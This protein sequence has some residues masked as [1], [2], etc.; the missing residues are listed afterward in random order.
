MKSPTPAVPLPP[1]EAAF[2]H[3]SL[4]HLQHVEKFIAI[5]NEHPS[6]CLGFHG[7][8]MVCLTRPHNHYCSKMAHAD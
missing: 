1:P 2:Q 4:F 7:Y 8:T 3:Q 5:L 6:S